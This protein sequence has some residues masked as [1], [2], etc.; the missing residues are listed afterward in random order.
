ERCCRA[1]SA[2]SRSAMAGSITKGRVAPSRSG[3][4]V[5]SW[6]SSCRLTGCGLM[7]LNV[8]KLGLERLSAATDLYLLLSGSD[9]GRLDGQ[10]LDRGIEMSGAHSSDPSRSR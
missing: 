9:E 2:R 8:W 7:L 6:S 3:C 10:P 1:Q 4:V 5:T